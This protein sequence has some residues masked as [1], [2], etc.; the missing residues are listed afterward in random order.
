MV[1]RSNPDFANL[2]RAAARITALV[3]IDDL[4]MPTI[5]GQQVLT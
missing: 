3:S 1:A 4:R 2:S 5:V